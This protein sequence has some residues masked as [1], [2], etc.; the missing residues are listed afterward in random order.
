MAI[1]RTCAFLS[2]HS[3][4]L[5]LSMQVYLS[6]ARFTPCRHASARA[7]PSCAWHVA[8]RTAW[9]S[10]QRVGGGL[11]RV[12]AVANRGRLVSSRRPARAVMLLRVCVA[13]SLL[14][15]LV[16]CLSFLVLR[17]ALARAVTLWP[18]AGEGKPKPRHVETGLLAPDGQEDGRRPVASRYVHRIR[19]ESWP[20]IKSCTYYSSS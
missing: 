1:C 18:L 20:D 3:S 6:Y 9:C 8:V 11:S 12:A 5:L 16:L 13:F 15:F 10:H 14:V 17:C 7:L 2:L 19:A 4:F